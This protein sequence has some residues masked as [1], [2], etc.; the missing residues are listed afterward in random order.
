MTEFDVVPN[1]VADASLRLGT[2][3]GSVDEV[4]GRLSGHLGAAAGT[5]AADAVDNLLGSFSKVL[6]QFALAGVQLSRAVGDAASGYAGTDSAVA[7][8]CQ[9]GREVRQEIRA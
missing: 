7:K 2:V 6:P 4:H 3:A 5:P 8:A 9:T 1:F